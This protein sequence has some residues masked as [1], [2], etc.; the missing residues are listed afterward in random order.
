MAKTIF[1]LWL[2]FLLLL[3]VIP[4]GNETSKALTD[5]RF[6]F[7]LDYLLHFAIM[8]VFAIIWV[9]GKNSIVKLFADHET[10]KYCAVVVAAGIGLE[11]LQLALPWRAFNPMD[12]FANLVG[13]AL[14][15]ALVILNQRSEMRA[16]DNQVK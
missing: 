5:N 15:V 11:L 8:L 4:L 14:A 6:I 1:W 2:L 9:V 7:R 16:V 12:L 3:N 13:A 10:H